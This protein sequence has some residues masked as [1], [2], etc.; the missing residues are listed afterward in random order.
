MQGTSFCYTRYIFLLYNVGVSS[1][2]YKL[3]LSVMQGMSFCY[4]RYVFLLCKVC[5]SV[6]EVMCFCYESYVFLL[7]KV[8]VSVMQGMCFCY[9]RY[10]FLLCKVCVSCKECFSIMH[11]MCFCSVFLLC[12]VM[13]Q[14]MQCIVA[15]KFLNFLLKIQVPVLCSF[16]QK[17]YLA[18]S[19]IFCFKLIVVSANNVKRFVFFIKVFKNIN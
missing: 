6:M 2:L 14:I 10:V 9:T 16:S 18:V 11:S 12:N 13:M 4:A 1:L 3:C 15:S 7:H 5:V 8:C 17:Y 19:I